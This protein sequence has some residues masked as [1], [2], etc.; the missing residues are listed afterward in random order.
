MAVPC[1]FSLASRWQFA[2]QFNVTTEQSAFYSDKAWLRNDDDALT[3]NETH[4]F[5]FNCLCV[6]R[7]CRCGRITTCCGIRLRLATSPRFVWRLT[8]SGYQTSCCITRKQVTSACAAETTVRETTQFQTLCLFVVYFDYM[9]MYDVMY[10]CI[11][12]VRFCIKPCRTY[13]GHV[14]ACN[15]S[16]V[17]RIFHCTT[18]YTSQR[19]TKFTTLCHAKSS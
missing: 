12:R 19:T 10:T 9:Y 14:V 18:I 11:C 3:L 5:L 15:T 16:H 6:A 1:C 17:F 4:S 8:V 13:S 7:G 2:Q